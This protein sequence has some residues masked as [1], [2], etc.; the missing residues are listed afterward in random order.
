MKFK[1][2][3]EPIATRWWLVGACATSFLACLLMWTRICNG[4]DKSATTSSASNKVAA[5]TLSLIQEPIIMSDVHLLVAIH[6][7]FLSPHFKWIQL[8]DPDVGGTPR[9]MSQQ[10]EDRT[11]E[12]WMQMDEY[13]GF[14]A[15]IQPLDISEKTCKRKN[16][17][18]FCKLYALHSPNTFVLGYQPTS[19]FSPYLVKKKQH[20]LLQS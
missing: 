11:N 6:T 17:R 16:W 10:I 13:K 2:L 3:E 8:G 4:I 12:N 15:S 18:I 20:Q 19:S 5:A 9:F 7:W 1:K 14:V